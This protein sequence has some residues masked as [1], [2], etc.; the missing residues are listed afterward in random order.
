MQFTG[1]EVY[2]ESGNCAL[3]SI[4]MAKDQAATGQANGVKRDREQQGQQPFLHSPPHEL[5]PYYFDYRLEIRE[6]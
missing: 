2:H 5:N 4:F 6:K 3:P 1:I